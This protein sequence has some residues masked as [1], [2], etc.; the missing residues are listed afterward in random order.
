VGRF[1]DSKKYV[2]EYINTFIKNFR[3]AQVANLP[4]KG[5]QGIYLLTCIAILGQDRTRQ[6][7]GRSRGGVVDKPWISRGYLLVSCT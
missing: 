2:K 7:G 6:A 3:A 1:V 4:S 5:Q